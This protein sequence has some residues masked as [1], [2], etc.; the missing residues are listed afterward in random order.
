MRIV[1]E[2][3]KEA[4][5]KKVLNNLY[6][7]TAMQSAFHINMLALVDQQPRVINLK[8]ALQCYIDFRHEVITRRSRFELQ[9]AKDRAHIL[10]GFK[11]A[12]YHMV[13]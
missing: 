11:I 3:K 1:I 5:P 4:Q 13:K 2:L 12:L 7:F 9:K 6:K 8:Q 10:E